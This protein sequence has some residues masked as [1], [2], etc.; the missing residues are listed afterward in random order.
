[1]AAPKLLSDEEFKTCFA[2]PMRDITTEANA[3][4]DI[5]PYCN[6]IDLYEL[7][8]P[9]LSDVHYVY[10]DAGDRFDQ[11]LIGTGRFNSLLVVVVDL[12][13]KS[14]VGHHVLDLNQEYG[15]AGG[16]I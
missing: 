1:M 7:G 5:W 12:Q 4:V 9:H 8:I 14:I 3:V 11:V 16:H 10:R 13:L 15:T 6:S 2:E